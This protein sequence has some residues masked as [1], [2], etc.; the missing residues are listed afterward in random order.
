MS[1]I[2]YSLVHLNVQETDRLSIKLVEL[3]HVCYILFL[4]LYTY[5]LLIRAKGLWVILWMTQKLS[6]N[7]S[8]HKHYSIFV[9]NINH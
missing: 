5:I 2:P 3:R 4:Y 9:I 8:K 7:A 1:V 6:T